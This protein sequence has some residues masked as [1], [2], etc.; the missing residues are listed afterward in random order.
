MAKIT[1]EIDDNLNDLVQDAIDGVK[2]ILK[3]YVEEND[4]DSLP[5]INNDLD[6][7][8]AVHELV[9]GL[10][11]VYTKQIDDIWYLHKQ[12]LIRA[13]EDA[14]VG[15]NPLENDGMAAIYH[16]IHAKLNNWYSEHGE[17]YFDSIKGDEIVDD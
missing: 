13:Y 4:P 10:V 12:E 8:G 9:D 6:Y 3:D 15:D 5:C 2:D 16:Y 1:I 11:P 14:G 7:S 17:D